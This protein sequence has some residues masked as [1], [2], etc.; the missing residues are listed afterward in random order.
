MDGAEAEAGA[1]LILTE[2]ADA[3][4]TGGAGGAGSAGTGAEAAAGATGGAGSV[5]TGAE[6][7]AVIVATPDAAVSLPSSALVRFIAGDRS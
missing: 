7:A 6:A 5:G 1:D 4:A 3:R 2:E